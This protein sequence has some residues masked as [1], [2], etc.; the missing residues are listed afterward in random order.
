M[1]PDV[2]MRTIANVVARLVLACLLIIFGLAAAALVVVW[3][4]LGVGTLIAGAGARLL[5]E[6]RHPGTS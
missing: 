1:V 2:T 4:P 3:P 5:H 6:H